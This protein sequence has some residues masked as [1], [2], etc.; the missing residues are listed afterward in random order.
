MKRKTLLLAAVVLAILGLFL[1][2]I[3]MQAE[4]WYISVIAILLFGTPVIVFTVRWLGR[5]RGLLLIAALGIYALLF[6]TIAIKTG[7]PY[8]SFGYSGL[9]GPKL[10]NAVPATVLIAWTP[11][12]LGILALLQ[13]IKPLWKQALLATLGLVVIDLVLD[14]GAVHIG[15]WSWVTPGIYYGVPLVNFI[16]WIISSGIAV[17]AIV[18]AKQ[19]LH[20]PPI[21]PMLGW[22]L[23]AIVFLWTTV[24]LFALQFI[25]AVLGLVIC[26]LMYRQLM[27]NPS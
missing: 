27:N 7:L 5:R 3:P 11:L 25:P 8:G 10:F 15:F 16:G 26:G 6:E 4:L 22:N 24:T 17:S 21:P 14:P 19:R 23:L 12:V 2:R 20:W 9:L 13:T 1:A 18:Y